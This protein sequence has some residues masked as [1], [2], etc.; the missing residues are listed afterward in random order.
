MTESVTSRDLR[1]MLDMIDAGYQDTPGE[2]LPSAVAEGLGQLVPC[3]SISFFELDPGHRHCG[4]H[5][6]VHKPELAPAFWL[7]YWACPPCSYPERTGTSG[8]YGRFRITIRSGNG[9]ARRC[10]PNIYVISVLS[11][12]SLYACRPFP[13][14]AS[15]A[16]PPRARRLRRTRQVAAGFAP[17]ASG[18]RVP[19]L[20]AAPGRCAEAD[21]S[22]MGAA[23]ARRCRKQ[24]CRNR[25]TALPVR[26]NSPQAS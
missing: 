9:I 13:A 23:P 6:C 21:C 12:S 7:H 18:G 2:G 26:R 1:A 22:P 17:P 25:P 20:P 4:G 24:Y 19:G 3:D 14:V 5:G 16:A 15:A 11:M 10:T 8:A